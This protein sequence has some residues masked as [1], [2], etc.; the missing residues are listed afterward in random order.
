MACQSHPV[1][2]D[3]ILRF[4][5]Y[6]IQLSID[7]PT[8]SDFKTH[9]EK[10][11]LHYIRKKALHYASIFLLMSDLATWERFMPLLKSADA[12][13]TR[14]Q[15]YEAQRASFMEHVEGILHEQINTNRLTKTM[16]HVESVPSAHLLP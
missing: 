1:G 14:F 9:A 7:F 13:H 2:E 4:A 3:M 6:S 8:A 12:K 16:T 5:T 10:W 15:L 11:V